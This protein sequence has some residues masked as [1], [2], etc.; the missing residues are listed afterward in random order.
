MRKTTIKKT[1]VCTALIASLAVVTPGQAE[2]KN[3]I[4]VSASN[5]Q[6]LHPE[7]AVKS[8]TDASATNPYLV[9]IGPGLY[10]LQAQ[11]RMKPFVEIEGSGIGVTRITGAFSSNTIDLSALIVGADNSAIRHLTLEHHGGGP[12]DAVGIANIKAGPRINDVKIIVSGTSGSSNTSYGI[13]NND[14]GVRASNVQIETSG[15]NAVG[16]LS[17]FAGGEF[18]GLDIH[19]QAR[20]AGKATGIENAEGAIIVSDSRVIAVG[21]ASQVGI[22]NQSAVPSLRN[23]VVVATGAGTSGIGVQSRASTSKPATVFLEGSEINGNIA[24]SL[25][26]Q[27][28]AIVT[29]SS[30]LSDY[31]TKDGSGQSTCYFS[32]SGSKELDGKCN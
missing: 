15:D 17:E 20:G 16:L 25:D 21:G 7:Q 18:R 10:P 27:S 30:L 22:F 6:F 19:A 29:R 4:T 13:Y 1:F 23:V 28:S 2:L 31:R 26:S 3:V 11:L 8:I 9:K 24:L 32:N 12:H 14:A 5:G